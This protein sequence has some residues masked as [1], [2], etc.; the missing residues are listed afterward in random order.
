M[1]PGAA[2]LRDFWGW[3]E[4]RGTGLEMKESLP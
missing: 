3:V 4:E 1:G 2:S